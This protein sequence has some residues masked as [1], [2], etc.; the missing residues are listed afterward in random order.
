MD[1]RKY[2]YDIFISYSRLDYDEVIAFVDMLKQRI[3]SIEIWM[4]LE[5]IDAA[6]EF[7]E[8]IIAAIDAS[9]YVIFAASNN[10]NSIGE[11]S[12][13][14]TKKEL[15]YAKNTGKK[16][17]PLLLTNA[18]LNSWFLFEFGRV[19]CI[20]IQKRREVEKLLKN[21][22]KWTGKELLKPIPTSEN[23]NKDQ[24]KE[25]IYNEFI[26]KKRNKILVSA[27]I[28]ISVII[29]VA[30]IY[31]AKKTL[32]FEYK[33][34]DLY[35]RHA[36]VGEK[37]KA[38]RVIGR[39]VIPNSIIRNGNRYEVT[40][41]EETA[42]GLCSSLTSVKLPNSIDTIMDS[43]FGEC[44]SLRRVKMSNNLE[45][46]GHYAFCACTSLVSI[47]IPSCVHIDTCAFS[48]CYSLEEIILPDN[49]EH[50]GEGAFCYC[51]SLR[52]IEIPSNVTRIEGSVFFNCESLTE[53]ILPKNL[54]QI[55]AFAIVNCDIL[56]NIKYNGTIEEWNS[57]D[58][59]AGWLLTTPATV[60]HCIDGDVEI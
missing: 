60:V 43:A 11:V 21:L 16:V 1:N 53:I 34:F 2:K 10:S 47:K 41:I 9:K 29:L 35:T 23:Q 7:D 39:I 12:S 37:D 52:S 15:V 19:D 6:D 40:K 59:S 46:I 24:I 48:H 42:F 51:E 5:G 58:K 22:S 54:K 45:Y 36:A 13:K 32:R 55:D 27:I 30:P 28:L 57:I 33:R 18:L 44:Y 38:F 56:S 50:L 49:L 4:D 3:P 25:L 17:I 14:W 26:L 8:K 20:N 31:I